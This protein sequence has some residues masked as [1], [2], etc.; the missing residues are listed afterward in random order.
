MYKVRF[1]LGK[2]ENFMKWKITD[3]K[4]NHTYY[5]PNEVVIKMKDCFLRNQKATA[6]KIHKGANKSV[7]AWVEAEEV[8][9]LEQRQLQIAFDKV[10][11]NP[12]VTPHWMLDG[13]IADGKTFEAMVSI[14]R[15]LFLQ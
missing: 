8:V 15:E 14:N 3:P 2:G 9:V 10:S 6:I 7:C 4:G 13:E 12:R 11:Y 1:N 5:Q